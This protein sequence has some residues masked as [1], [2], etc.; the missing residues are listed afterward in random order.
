MS[1]SLDLDNKWCYLK[2]HGSKEWESLPTYLDVAIPRI[3]EFLA[4][5][6]TKITFFIVGQD[7]VR[8]ENKAYL[9]MLA[10]AGHEIANHSFHHDPWLHL[11][12]PEKLNKE[13]EL[14]ENAIEDATGAKVKGFRG[15]GFSLSTETLQVIKERGYE[16]DA[17]AFPNLLNPL[18]RAY[19]FAKSNLSAEQKEERKALFG[20]YSDA[21]RPV[22]PYNWNLGEEKLLELPVTTMPLF[23]VPIHFS[24][25]VYL[26]SFASPLATLYTRVA[27]SLCRLTSTQP[28]LLLHPLDFLGSDD[29]S[30]LA[31]FPGMNLESD[32]KLE[33]M[34]KFFDIFSKHYEPVTMGEHISRIREKS[35]S[36]RTF[37]P[38]FAHDQNKE[39][40]VAKQESQEP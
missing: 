9:R 17:T 24:Y 36:L 5:R 10:D 21:F 13:L 34:D 1:L 12:T 28:S 14:A 3:L 8:E 32:K 22:K 15:P 35:D 23:K 2:T 29:D 4:R 38:A 6:D 20:S 31:F 11:Y 25:L 30:D 40:P 18:A 19:F 33:L 27:T 7:A 16:Y 39:E 37:E 26:G